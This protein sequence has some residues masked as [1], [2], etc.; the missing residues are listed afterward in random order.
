MQGDP[1]VPSHPWER[2]LSEPYYQ[3]TRTGQR[4]YRF[5]NGHGVS[6][7][8]HINGQSGWSM[9]VIKHTDEKSFWINIHTPFGP[10]KDGLTEEAVQ[11]YLAEIEAYATT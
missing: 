1:E 11:K 4:L 9:A 7:A 10:S 6:V 3:S 2:Q 8:K 5:A